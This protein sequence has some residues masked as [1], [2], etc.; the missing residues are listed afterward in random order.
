MAKK[1]SKKN[2][3]RKSSSKKSKGYEPP[4][5]GA[6][7][8]VPSLP[9]PIIQPEWEDAPIIATTHT[10]T[11]IELGVGPAFLDTI[12]EN[13]SVA[14][15]RIANLSTASAVASST[16]ENDDDEEQGV[17]GGGGN[18]KRSK[19]RRAKS[20]TSDAA[21]LA[22]GD[23]SERIEQ[24]QGT[25]PAC[26]KRK[27]I[28]YTVLAILLIGIAVGVY[29]VVVSTNNKDDDRNSDP[30]SIGEGDNDV[31]TTLGNTT[32]D[33][34]PSNDSSGG[35][36]GGIPA[37]SPG[38][39][40]ENTFPPVDFDYW[41]PESEFPS[42][43][44]SMA[45]RDRSD[46]DDILLDVSDQQFED[47]D[48]YDITTSHGICRNNMISN[49]DM[50]PIEVGRLRI[51]QRYILCLLQVQTS[52]DGSLWNIDWSIQ[53]ECDWEGISC[54]SNHKEVVVI[55]LSEYN[56]V[57][58]I[59]YE[60]TKLTKLQGLTLYGNQLQGSIPNG[61]LFLPN[62]IECNLSNNQLS[63]SI[64]HDNTFFTPSSSIEIL[65]LASNELTGQIPLYEFPI[66][67]EVW[68]QDNEF[69]GISFRDG[70]QNVQYPQ[71]TNLIVYNNFL[72][73][74]I[75]NDMYWPSVMPNVINLDISENLWTGMLPESMWEFPKIEALV[76]HDCQFTGSIFGSEENNAVASLSSSS[77]QHVWLNGNQF[78]GTLPQLTGWN[79]SSLTSFLLHDNSQLYGSIDSTLCG[80]WLQRE[81][82]EMD[83]N[84]IVP[85]ACCTTCH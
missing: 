20:V 11:A 67:H 41:V 30:D 17:G 75:P 83:C 46:V 55:S 42:M 22:G 33:G 47:V 53:D 84:N 29:F 73:G 63:G 35:G 19:K 32:G 80:R 5:S 79:W 3:Q 81:Q 72:G 39:G 68:L 59:P 71:L 18:K 25:K 62:L 2:Q 49:G 70:R 6:S 23:D 61:L 51:E 4:D 76:A 85:C 26:T 58:T 65:K 77:I 15:A 82:I 24:P 34:E 50:K 57:G 14:A 43:A 37:P 9:T 64:G 78:T 28:F 40:D 69:T 48:I 31:N 12:P 13:E 54:T 44:P 45:W 7:T 8:P 66:I 60:L 21:E 10:A 74:S 1:S 52:S 27:W 38:I 16:S 36:T 56:L